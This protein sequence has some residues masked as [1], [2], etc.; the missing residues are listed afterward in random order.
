MPLRVIIWVVLAALASAA[1]L[2]YAAQVL[3]NGESTKT[4]EGVSELVIE[5]AVTPAAQARG[6]SGRDEIPENYGMLFV[7]PTADVQGFWM[8]DML[9]SIDIIWLDDAGRIV[10]IEPEVS[11]DTYPQIYSAPTPVRYV[12]EMR[13]GSAAARGWKVGT[14]VPIEL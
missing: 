1:F 3:F 10:G 2:G 6:L 7:F 4:T 9:V 12:L 14:K 8:K 13:A 5:R 11:P